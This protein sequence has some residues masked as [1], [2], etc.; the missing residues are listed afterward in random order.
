MGEH[1]PGDEF[2]PEEGVPA[3]GPVPADWNPRGPRV[4]RDPV[5]AYDELRERCPVARGA[6]GAWTLFSHAEVVAAALD[7]ETFANAVSRHLQ[8]PN[9]LD[10]PA[11][12]AFRAV[13]ER[14]FTPQRTAALGPVVRRTAEELV[15]DLPVPGAVDAV[16]LGARFAVRAQ[17][18]WLGWDP[19]LEEELLRW[20]AEHR[21]ATRSRR[22]ERTAAAARRFDA[23]VRSQT[24]PRRAA[25]AH[26]PDD[27][28]TELL[29][30]RVEGR[31]LTEEEVVS[32]LR[33]WTGGDLG[34]M[35]LCAGVVLA[36]LADH[37]QR[38]ERL[39]RGVPDR[40][41]G[42]VLDE[43]LRLDDPFVQNRRVTTRP[44]TAG[45]RELAAGERVF[46]NWTAANRDP[47]VFGEPGDFDP[48]GHA[49]YNLVWG[50][51]KHV[52]PGRPLATL[53]LRELTRAV[54][55][56]T[57]ALVPDPRQP[58][59]REVPPGGGYAAVP[60]LLR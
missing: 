30:E 36:H 46:L 57:T 4:R 43:I 28:T 8:V 18:A 6:G 42:Q 37:P 16:A 5:A 22:P 1:E 35:A 33:N 7:H 45:G 14:F 40:E 48:V 58:R 20:T 31:P 10:G 47:R 56:A 12:T 55:A 60:L 44:V 23:L 29:R 53:E 9:G 2:G 25:G 17:L 19:G 38:Q 21:A 49:P 51:G 3:P 39:R 13:V 41:L 15:A 52:C 59:E 50:I 27:V 54:L 26:A 11:H 32:V 34:S 24:A